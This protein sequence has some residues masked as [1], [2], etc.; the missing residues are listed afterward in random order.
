MNE[1]LLIFRRDF[2]TKEGQLSP[3]QLQRSLKDWQDWF[4]KITEQHKLARPPQRWDGKGKVVKS[5]KMV[6]DGPYVEVKESIGGMIFIN[7]KDYEEAA[8]IAKGCP[9][10]ALGGNV[11][12]RKAV[13][14]EASK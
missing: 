8:E 9:I 12:I 13:T 11:E 2:T 1:F 7:A 14:P 10:L 6:T 3:E 5:D 4:E